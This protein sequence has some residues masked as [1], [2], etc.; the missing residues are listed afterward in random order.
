M[1]EAGVSYKMFYGMSSVTAME[2]HSGG[3][4]GYRAAEGKTVRVAF[5]GDVDHTLQVEN[6]L[7]QLS[8]VLKY[9]RKVELTSKAHKKSSAK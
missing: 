6:K 5:R 4:A 1:E 2:K 9:C 8:F 3:V 7:Q